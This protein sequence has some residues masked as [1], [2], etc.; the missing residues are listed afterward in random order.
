L[1]S[2]ING[3]LKASGGSIN[4]SSKARVGTVHQQDEFNPL[5]PLTVYDVVSIG[6]IVGTKNGDSKKEIMD[7]RIKSAL[8]EFGISRL[9]KRTFRSLSGGERQKVQ[10]CR[11]MVQNPELLLLDEP[12]NNLDMDW[13]EKLIDLI[14]GIYRSTGKTV[15]MSTHIIGHLPPCCGRLFMLKAGRLIF[16]G[17]IDE[18]LTAGYLEELYG[19]RV[20]IRS[21]SGRRHCFSTGAGET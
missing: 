15:I 12:T 17:P 13:Q 20:S 5:I 7:K 6:L 21:I 14:D 11:A 4:I 16:D 9:S 19:C 10:L 18:G 8:E 2:L 1:L 3:T